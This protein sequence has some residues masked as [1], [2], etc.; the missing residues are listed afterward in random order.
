MPARSVSVR[1]VRRIR[2]LPPLRILIEHRSRPQ[3][4]FHILLQLPVKVVIAWKIIVIQNYQQS[5]G[6]KVQHKTLDTSTSGRSNNKLLCPRVQIQRHKRTFVS[7]S[8]R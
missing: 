2:S 3:K 8:I 1:I 5:M 7:F 6:Y 4:F